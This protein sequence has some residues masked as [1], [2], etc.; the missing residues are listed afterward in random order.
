[1]HVHDEDRLASVS[2]LGK[3]IEIG[4]VQP[5]VSAGKLKGGTGMMV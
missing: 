4:E 2:Q 3:R 5:G 1:V